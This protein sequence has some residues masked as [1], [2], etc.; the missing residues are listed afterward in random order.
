[1]CDYSLMGVPN[2]LAQERDELLVHR[3]PTGTLGLASRADLAV[4]VEQVARQPR[5]FWAALRQFF[6]PPDDRAVCAVCIPPGAILDVHDIPAKLQME[7]NI[8]SDERVVFTQTTAAVNHHRDAFRFAGGREVRLQDL[9]EGQRV[10]VI[11][12]SSAQDR[13]IIPEPAHLSLRT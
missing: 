8:G 13:E 4:P 9:R 7:L 12:L 11:D 2:R 6:D 5:S 1:M 3:F 10:E